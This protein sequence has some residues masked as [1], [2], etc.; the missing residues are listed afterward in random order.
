MFDIYLAIDLVIIVA[1]LLLAAAV[2]SQNRRTEL[3]RVF[4]LSAVSVT[5]WI[6]ANYISNDTTRSPDAA[7]FAN[8]F[9]FFF[10]YQNPAVIENMDDLVLGFIAMPAGLLACWGVYRLLKKR[11]E[12]EVLNG[13][14]EM[15]GRDIL[16]DEF[17][18]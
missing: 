8:H 5:I 13:N 14:Y 12:Q 6:S 9:V 3:N 7:L 4:A 16:D 11:W 2:L 17:L 18:N 10:S 1:L 15:H